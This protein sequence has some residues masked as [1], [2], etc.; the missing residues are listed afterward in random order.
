MKKRN[1]KKKGPQVTEKENGRR[2]TANKE[3]SNDF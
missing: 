3:G 1:V 2:K